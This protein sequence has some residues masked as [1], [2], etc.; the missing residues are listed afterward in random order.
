MALIR[1]SDARCFLPSPPLN[2]PTQR[3]MSAPSWATHTLSGA[4]SSHAGPSSAATTYALPWQSFNPNQPPPRAAPSAFTTSAAS[5]DLAAP[6]RKRKDS[7]HVGEAAERSATLR[8][9]EVRALARAARLAG[10]APADGTADGTAV[11]GQQ[12]QGE[13][14]G[15]EKDPLFDALVAALLPGREAGAMKALLE[16]ASWN[17]QA[18]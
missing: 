7:H 17:V 5:A 3:K 11:P 4:G 13:G 14:G 18:G 16:R 12:K 10:L 15:G 8:P 2:D 6:S 9:S 1:Q